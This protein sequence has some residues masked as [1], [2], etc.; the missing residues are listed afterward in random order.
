MKTIGAIEVIDHG[1]EHS[2][3]F[4]GCGTSFTRFENVVT[5]IG[6]N[7]A[8]AIDD[9]L[10]S[11]AQQGYDVDALEQLIK[12]EF[13]VD[14]LP[15]SPSVSALS[16]TGDDDAPDDDAPDYSEH[17]YHVSIRWNEAETTEPVN[18]DA[19][20][21][22]D[23]E[24]YAVGDAPVPLRQYAGIKAQ[25]MRKRLAGAIN[26][27]LELEQLADKLYKALPKQFRTW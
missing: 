2:Q 1:I 25:A 20:D 24:A 12:W 19:E 18:L 13:N 17:H 15:T 26:A 16:E 6:D 9:C 14:T 8:E 3:Y 10:E 5:G 27:A 7:F 21:V 22:G 11:I 23:L 4:Q